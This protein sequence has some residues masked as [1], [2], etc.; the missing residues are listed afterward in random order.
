M[1]DYCPP[2][3]KKKNMTK[4]S[5]PEKTRSYVCECTRSPVSP[6]Y[7]HRSIDPQQLLHLHQPPTGHAPNEC[8][9]TPQE[10]QNSWWHEQ[11]V[12]FPRNL[13]L[14]HK[15]ETQDARDVG[16]RTVVRDRG[17]IHRGGM[18]G[19]GGGR[20]DLRGVSDLHSHGMRPGAGWLSLVHGTGPLRS[21]QMVLLYKQSGTVPQTSTA[22]S[23]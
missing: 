19:D 6:P 11:H 9:E 12:C 21:S 13:Y 4:K 20:G 2:F 23:S 14:V 1:C 16:I 15:I 3:T 7:Y 10:S 22:R 8:V 5:T 17:R 18:G